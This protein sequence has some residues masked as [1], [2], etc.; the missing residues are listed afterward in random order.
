M[1]HHIVV[2]C[3]RYAYETVAWLKQSCSK[4]NCLRLYKVVTMSLIKAKDIIPYMEG[5]G[6]GEWGGTLLS[7][8]IYTH[9]HAHTDQYHNL[10]ISQQ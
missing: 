6:P 9:M 8:H 4:V 3:G 5:L 2:H 10:A 7:I 1:L